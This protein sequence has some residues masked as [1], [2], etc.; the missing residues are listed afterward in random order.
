MSFTASINYWNMIEISK[1]TITCKIYMSAY[2]AMLLPISSTTSVVRCHVSE[3][4]QRYACSK[5]NG[6][7]VVV[8]TAWLLMADRIAYQSVAIRLLSCKV[9]NVMTYNPFVVL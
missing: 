1:N 4:D 8:V 7:R 9:T 3:S 2:Y 6:G 5:K